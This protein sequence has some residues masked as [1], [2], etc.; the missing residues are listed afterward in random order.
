MTMS[1]PHIQFALNCN[2]IIRQMQ[3]EDLPKIE[4]HGQF[5]HFRTM[6]MKSYA[7]QIQGR[8]HLL[9]A[10]MNNYP[11][12]RLFILKRDQT[13]NRPQER[14]RGYLYSFQ[15]LEPFQGMGI[16]SQLLAEAQDYLRRQQYGL[17]TI[18]VARVN[19]R[20]LRLYQR[21]GFRI[22]AEDAGEWTYTDHRGTLRKVSEP[23]YLLEKQLS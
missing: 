16:G 18:S 5:T 8:R 15:V 23:C 21:H 22:F 6:F 19:H 4:W 1:E 11:I 10:V 14:R 9:V 3:Q 12:G 20:A 2:I 17:A 7:E 13:G